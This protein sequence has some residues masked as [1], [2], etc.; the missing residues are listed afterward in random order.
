M[1]QHPCMLR[2]RYIP[3]RSTCKVQWPSMPRSCLGQGEFGQG[4]ERLVGEGGTHQPKVTRTK[5][6]TRV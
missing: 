4:F 3:A 1:S 6:Q 2:I 5:D